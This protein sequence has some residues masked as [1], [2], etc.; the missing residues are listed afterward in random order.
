MADSDSDDSNEGQLSFDAM[1]SKSMAERSVGTYTQKIN[2]FIAY[3]L[4]HPVFKSKVDASKTLYE[5]VAL[6]IGINVLKTF[7]Q[8]QAYVSG[9]SKELKAKST[10][11]GF[12]SALVFY[13]KKAG[14][15]EMPLD[16]R[17]ALKVFIEGFSKVKASNINDGI[18]VSNIYYFHIFIIF[19]SSFILI[20]LTFLFIYIVFRVG[21]L[22]KTT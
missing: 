8:K 2:Q 17:N 9:G 6:P 19:C 13:Y 20:N 16:E 21:K 3:L 15:T 11:K 1:Q 12:K 14:Y 7:F 4:S 5:K 18:E 10:I 22:A